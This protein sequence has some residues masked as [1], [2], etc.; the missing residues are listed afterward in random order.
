MNLYAFLTSL[1]LLC[2]DPGD[3]LLLCLVN[4]TTGGNL[5]SFPQQPWQQGQMTVWLLGL[6]A[7]V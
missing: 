2:T 5:V 3:H 1:G 6:L 4:A 7:T